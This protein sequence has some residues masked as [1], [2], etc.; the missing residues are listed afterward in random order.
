MLTAL[1]DSLNWLE[2]FCLSNAAS[3]LDKVFGNDSLGE[4]AELLQLSGGRNYGTFWDVINTGVG[5]VRPF[6]IALMTTY[7]LMYLY[8]AAVK[9]QITIDALIKVLIQLVLVVTLISNYEVI[10]NALLSMGESVMSG[11]KGAISSG[12]RYDANGNG[13]EGSAGLAITGWDVVNA[14]YEN[15]GSGSGDSAATILFQCIFF[16]IVHLIAKVATY[17]AIFSRLIELGW[18]IVFGPIGVANA[19]E[20]GANSGSIKYLKDVAGLAVAGAAVLIVCAVGSSISATMLSVPSAADCTNTTFLGAVG[21]EMATAGAAIG[22]AN[23]IKA[24]FG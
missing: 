13:I 2:K 1:L 7:F 17:F 20:G 10:I 4:I 23:K 24:V 22:V 12:S 19:F 3:C 5:I 14:W 18:K 8:D 9:D 16:Q 15:T 21:A 11:M 6:G